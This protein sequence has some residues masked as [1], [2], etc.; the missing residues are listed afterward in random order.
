MGASK[1]P[2]CAVEYMIGRS[3]VTHCVTVMW[4]S[5]NDDTVMWQSHDTLCWSHSHVTLCAVMWQVTWHIM[6]TCDTSCC[7]VTV[8]WHIT[9][10]TQSCDNHVTHVQWPTY[11]YRIIVWPHCICHASPG[12]LPYNDMVSI[13]CVYGHVAQRPVR[14]LHDT[15]LRAAQHGTSNSCKKKS[16]YYMLDDC[17]SLV[18]IGLD[19]YKR[20]QL[21]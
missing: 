9:L 16:G 2:H 20:A 13:A 17:N 21:N 7:C 19:S 11:A 18:I 4:K 12:S 1:T 8:T 6:L 10:I 15:I 3:H 14:N 5:C